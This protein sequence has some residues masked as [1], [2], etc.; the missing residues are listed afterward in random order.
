V[1][2]A[3][4]PPISLLP[5]ALH[6]K[7]QLVLPQLLSDPMYALFYK[8]LGEVID[9]Y[10]ILD[11]GAAEGI[12]H[13]HDQLLTFC[14][15]LKV[16]ELVLPDVIGDGPGTVRAVN[17]FLNA[18]VPNSSLGIVAAGRSAAEAIDTVKAILETQDDYIDIVYV[19]RSLVAPDRLYARIEVAS[20]VKEFAPNK[21]IHFLGTN[22]IWIREVQIAAESQIVRGVDTSAPFNYAFYN[23]PVESEVRRSRPQGYFTFAASAFPSGILNSNLAT[24][25]EWANGN[26]DS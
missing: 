10:L 24:L 8:H 6:T 9:Q 22:P 4:I 11:N 12:H 19:P 15:R 21:D 1:R 14:D 23:K 26:A 20:A 18:G 16:D 2:I 17:E 3:F 13:T 25:L 5:L 7:Y